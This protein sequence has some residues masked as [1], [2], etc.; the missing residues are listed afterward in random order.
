MCG[1]A[2]I[3]D[4]NSNMFADHYELVESADM[5]SS[6]ITSRGPD[7]S[8]SWSSREEGI[9][10]CHRRL[11]ILDLSSEGSQPMQSADDRYVI[12]YNGEI[13]NYLEIQSELIQL[14][15]SFRGHSDTEVLLAAIS[16]W[17]IKKALARANGMFAFAL[18]DKKHKALTFARDRMG[19]KPLY[20]MQQKG[21]LCFSSELKG[22]VY[23]K[24]LDFK[25]NQ[26][27]VD[28]FF[29]Y[30]YVP[31]CTSIYQDVFKL[32]PGKVIRFSSPDDKP[33][34]ESFWNVDE[35]A[36]NA[37]VDPVAS[38]EE[39]SV[40]KLRELLT[41]AVKIRCR[42]DVPLGCFLSGGIDSSI[43]TALMSEQV[44]QLKTYTVGFPD[45][46]YDESIFA[47]QVADHFACDHH[48][49][50][51]G[52]SDIRTGI[53]N[54]PFVYD[55][56]FADI[57]QIPTLLISEYARKDVTVCLSGDG[58]DEVFGGY[59]RHFIAA[60]LWPRLQ[61]IPASLRS[62]SSNMLLLL[63]SVLGETLSKVMAVML[64]KK[65]GLRT[66]R[67]KLQ[68]TLK[69]LSARDLIELHDILLS[70]GGGYKGLSSIAT[71]Q[72]SYRDIVEKL[73]IS[74]VRK[75]M[76]LD[77]LT[78]LPDDVLVKTD[79]ASMSVGL[80]LRSPLLDYRVFDFS[81][82]LPDNLLV[83]NNSGKR[84]LKKL[85]E[86]YIP[87]S[88]F[89]RPKMGFAVPVGDWLRGPLMDWAG[90]LICS[91]PDENMHGQEYKKLW[92]EHLLGNKD[93]SHI[94][95]RYLMWSYWY[96]AW[97]SQ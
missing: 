37:V 64:G 62:S 5:I 25:L 61:T 30:G 71:E 15:C 31:G 35:M 54:L 28:G 11:S 42:S 34:T 39:Q 96:E 58:G 29:K 79:R 38:S 6:A 53:D 65:A 82:H 46:G 2:G 78:F 16:N 81:W 89:E 73:D 17:G 90:D 18:W 7:A 23:L 70:K 51:M 57:S 49:Y 47:K 66:P 74:P 10:L 40:E 63:E 55:E 44:S 95:W 85:L 3:W 45:A 75:M 27:A 12:T 26:D 59:N 83:E 41:D 13:Y 93:H 86:S 72:C 52:Y 77:T 4:K 50:Q 91:M 43:I 69:A 88:L 87:S 92:Q 33:E 94:L 84:I 1:I 80:E 9:A 48:T 20:I 22:L 60:R 97:H 76:L 56:P 8:G 14:G 32:Q 24:R 21:M 68:K 67:D 19:K 36:S